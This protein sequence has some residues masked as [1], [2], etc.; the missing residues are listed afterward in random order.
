MTADGEGGSAL[1]YFLGETEARLDELEAEADLVSVTADTRDDAKALIDRVKAMQKRLG[2]L[3]SEVERRIVATIPF[4][5]DEG[6]SETV[7]IQGSAY[8]AGY[9]GWSW[10]GVDDRREG[11]EN[12]DGTKAAARADFLRY[13][14]DT[15]L[16][17]PGTGEVVDQTTKILRVATLDAGKARTLLREC[18]LDASEWIEPSGSLKLREVR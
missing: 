3:A 8:R 9:S 5:A 1:A 14:N 6:R 11:A 13:L 7:S 2:E 16:V 18:K 4:N 10:R 17:I 15:T 12:R